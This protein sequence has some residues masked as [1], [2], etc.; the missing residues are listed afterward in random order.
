MALAVDL[1]LLK[2]VSRG[3]K[4]DIKVLC[5]ASYIHHRSS[6]MHPKALNYICKRHKCANEPNCAI[7]STPNTLPRTEVPRKTHVEPILSYLIVCWTILDVF[8]ATCIHVELP[9]RL[10]VV[11]PQCACVGG[12]IGQR[13]Y[14]VVHPIIATRRKGFPETKQHFHHNSLIEAGV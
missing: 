13:S 4:K 9:L 11:Q 14:T 7:T 2:L 12:Y 10:L 5:I 1:G 6:Q 8:G 3:R